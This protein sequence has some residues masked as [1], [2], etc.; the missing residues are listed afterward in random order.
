[1]KGVQFPVR[2][3]YT[4]R[5]RP[6]QLREQPSLFLGVYVKW[7]KDESDRSPPSVPWF[8]CVALYLR[9]S[10]FHGVCW[11]IKHRRI[12]S[13]KV[14][15]SSMTY[16]FEVEEEEKTFS[17]NFLRW[18]QIFL[19]TRQILVIYFSCKCYF[20]SVGFQLFDFTFAKILEEL[21]LWQRNSFRL[22]RG[23]WR[24]TAFYFS[25][26]V[27]IP[28]FTNCTIIYTLLTSVVLLWGCKVLECAKLC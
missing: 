23:C 12:Y 22:S 17:P 7:L 16:T 14:G 21:K 8:R 10:V 27:F 25:Y 20:Q 28:L 19:W 3:I 1:M 11:L 5:H 18:L 15:N 4:S 24:K 26:I 2:L 6:D 9:F 13:L